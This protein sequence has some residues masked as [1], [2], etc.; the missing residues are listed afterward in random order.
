MQIGIVLP[1]NDGDGP[2][3]SRW[4]VIREVAVTAES[5]GLDSLWAYDHLLF[6]APG[7]EEGGPHDSL[8]MLAA[9]AAVTSRV[10]LGTIVLGTGF[11][12]P[13]VTAKS[14]VVIDEVSDGRLVLG[15]GAGWHEPEYAAFGYP[16]D[17]RVGRFDEFLA[18]TLPLLRGERV[19]F[20]GQWHDAQDAVLLPP[21]PRPTRLPGRMPI[22]IAS[23]GERMRRLTAQHA[24]AWNAAWFGVP[25]ERFDTRRAQLVEACEAEG[26]D[27][28]T[29]EVTAGLIVD[30]ATTEANA[31][32]LPPDADAI[33]GALDAWRDVGIGHV[34]LN[35]Q[36]TTPA[37]VEVVAAA[38]AKHRGG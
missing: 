32:S 2:D 24:D 30:A 20:H 17:H 18:I 28:A 5:A 33:A 36:P 9:V 3:G 38:A 13:V 19:T 12:S 27:A 22:L 35:L 26:R 1:L 23:R 21:P 7:E 37:L 8:T 11:R 31:D 15:L 4:P 29:L 14:A 25:S 16:F 10:A 6:R 34:Q